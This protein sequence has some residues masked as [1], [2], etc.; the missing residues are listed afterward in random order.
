[1]KIALALSG[2]G[3]RAVAHL[4]IIKVLIDNG[5]KIEAI[6]GSSAGALI[7]ALLCDGKSPEEILKI[8]KTIKMWD[9][10]KGIRRGGLFGLNGVKEILYNNLTIKNIEDSNSKLF[11]ACTDLLSGKIYYF[12]NG[13]VVEL[14]IASSSLVPIISPVKHD[15]MLLADGGFIDNL[16]VIPL[17]KTGL[18]IIG[19]NVNPIVKKNPTNFLKTTL[20]VL[21]LMMNSNIETSKKDCDFFIEPAS[22]DKFNIFDLKRAD[23]AYEIGV[24]EAIRLLPKL[25]SKLQFF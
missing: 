20:R 17:K 18:P 13:P 22:C 23:E 4:G 2:G 8:V 19:I 6:S 1:M 14:S 10:M 5:F 12:E 11:I 15:G 7:G 24:S 16:P 21:I 3:V 9:L 25:K